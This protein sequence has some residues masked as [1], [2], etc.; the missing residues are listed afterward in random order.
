VRPDSH[1]YPQLMMDSKGYLHLLHSFHGDHVVR[2]AKS[3]KPR[4]IE[5]WTVSDINDTKS[6][7]YGAAFRAK[8]DDMYYYFRHRDNKKGERDYEPEYYLKS[9]DRGKS[10]KKHILIYPVTDHPKENDGWGT[11]YTKSMHYVTKPVEGIQ[12]VFGIHKNHNI[13]LDEHYYV[14]HSFKDDNMYS[15]DGKNRGRSLNRAEIRKHCLLFK[16]GKAVDFYNVRT[17]IDMT[18]DGTPYLFHNYRDKL[19]MRFWNGKSWDTINTGMT[20]Y[21]PFELELDKT[22]REATLY[23]IE[24]R[25]KVRKM[26]FRD[27]LLVSNTVLYEMKESKQRLD[28]LT[29]FKDAKPEL[30]GFFFQG[31]K[32]EWRKPT[33]TGNLIAITE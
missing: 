4:S 31:V 12:I 15:A 10:W 8:N 3:N 29:F 21:S 25:R 20:R 7:T 24:S 16:H 1:N 5:E 13:Y 2:Y 32:S 18:E 6:A 26:V 17:A 23:A 9:T 11:V 27:K 22:G 14:F 28:H 33:P 19:L 30:K